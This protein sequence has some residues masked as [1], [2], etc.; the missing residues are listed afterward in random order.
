[1]DIPDPPRVEKSINGSFLDT[2]G[3][4]VLVCGSERRKGRRHEII[5]V[6]RQEPPMRTTA[7]D[8]KQ[9]AVFEP[10]H[11]RE[12]SVQAARHPV[13]ESTRL[14]PSTGYPGTEFLRGEASLR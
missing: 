14:A 2:G 9:L 8:S 5:F 12:G 13:H 4:L 6:R 1:M 7:V 11:E 10:A 3:T